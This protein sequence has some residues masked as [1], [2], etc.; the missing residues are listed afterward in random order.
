MSKKVKEFLVRKYTEKWIKENEGLF[1]DYQELCEGLLL[2]RANW[3][4]EIGFIFKNSK[5]IKGRELGDEAISAICFDEFLK[6][7]KEK[8]KLQK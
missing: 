1:E 4:I 6:N 5:E 8:L 3:G 7:K 2:F